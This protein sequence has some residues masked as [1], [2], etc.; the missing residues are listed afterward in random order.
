MTGLFS[1]S[2]PNIAHRAAYARTLARQQRRQSVALFLAA[3]RSPHRAA[4][5]VL[6]LVAL[7]LL[8]GRIPS[9]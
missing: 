9:V 1:R 5:A 4:V 7:G 8:A 6:V 2:S 3:V